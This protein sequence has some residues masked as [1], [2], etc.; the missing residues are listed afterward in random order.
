MRRTPLRVTSMTGTRVASDDRSVEFVKAGKRVRLRLPG[1]PDLPP[2]EGEPGS[3]VADLPEL[4]EPPE[5]TPAHLV[6]WDEYF[7]GYR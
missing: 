6:Y 3:A 5:P 7:R 4:A 2:A 1:L